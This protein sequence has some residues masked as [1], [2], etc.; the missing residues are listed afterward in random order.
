MWRPTEYDHI[1]QMNFMDAHKIG[2]MWSVLTVSMQVYIW[3]GLGHHIID[4]LLAAHQE[5][6][7][8]VTLGPVPHRALTCG[9]GT[10]IMRV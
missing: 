1:S 9:R 10:L 5:Q 6:V 3:H 2:L 4:D 8:V 7:Y